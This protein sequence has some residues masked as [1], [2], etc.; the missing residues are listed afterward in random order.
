MIALKGF[1]SAVDFD[2]LVLEDL[3]PFSCTESEMSLP[4]PSEESSSGATALLPPLV[5]GVTRVVS[6]DDSLFCYFAFVSHQKLLQSIS[7]YC[8]LYCL[9]CPYIQTYYNGIPVFFEYGLIPFAFSLI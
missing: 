7:C 6:D 3:S 8:R 9:D 2:C 1:S 5:L 4:L